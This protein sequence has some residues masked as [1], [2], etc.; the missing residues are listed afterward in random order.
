MMMR[1]DGSLPSMTKERFDRDKQHG[2]ESEGERERE[3]K[4]QDVESKNRCVEKRITTNYGHGLRVRSLCV[5]RLY[6]R[7]RLDARPSSTT[8]A[9]DTVKM[10][11]QTKPHKKQKKKREIKNKT[12]DDRMRTAAPQLAS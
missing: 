3:R 9:D 4:E 8:P 1:L 11:R 7:G 5:G 6:K 10:R 2:I 12:K